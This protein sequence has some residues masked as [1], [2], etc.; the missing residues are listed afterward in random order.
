MATVAEIRKAIKERKARS[1]WERGVKEY[2]L[3]LLDNVKE[4]RKLGENDLLENVTKEELLNGATDWQNYS[5]GGCSLV[6][7]EDIC[8]RLCSPSMQ[9]KKKYGELFPNRYENWIDVQAR[10]IANAAIRFCRA[11]NSMSKGK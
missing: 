5:E 6:Y 11:V 1:A 3:E 9:K 8:R 7:N 2:M 4:G 10:A